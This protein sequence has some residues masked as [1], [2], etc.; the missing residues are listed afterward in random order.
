MIFMIVKDFSYYSHHFAHLNVNKKGGQ[1]APHKPLLL[2]AIMDLVEQGIINSNRIELTDELVSTFDRKKRILTP[3][4][5]HFKPVIGT[6]FFH[7]QYEPFW[8]LVPR[9]PMDKP[10]TTAVST[11]QKFYV[12]AEIDQE[13]FLIM[14]NPTY[15]QLLR[16]ILLT[17]YLITRDLQINK[18]LSLILAATSLSLMIA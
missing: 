4:V 6:P 13:L 16:D 11:L 9:N 17:N 18:I 15:R 10:D 3:N 1:I 7:M 2:L 14:Q 12:Y 8:Q 5:R